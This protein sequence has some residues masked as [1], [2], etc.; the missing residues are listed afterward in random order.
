M[1]IGNAEDIDLLETI[2]RGEFVTTGFRNRD[3]QRHLHPAI[4]KGT[5]TQ[6]RRISAKISRQLRLLRAHG[7]IK[8]INRTYRYQLTIRG[9]K[10]AAAIQAARSAELNQA[11]QQTG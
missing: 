7:I 6:R 5:K 8:K 9:R 3:L 2:S 1:R 4:A 11:L 10:L